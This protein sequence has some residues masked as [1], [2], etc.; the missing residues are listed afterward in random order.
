MLALIAASFI[1]TIRT[2]VN[3]TRNLIV[4]AE[5]EALADAGVYRAIHELL[6]PQSEGLLSPQI[7]NLL[8]RGPA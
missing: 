4:N 7:E 1:R 8:R 2:E 3:L 6:S 5:A